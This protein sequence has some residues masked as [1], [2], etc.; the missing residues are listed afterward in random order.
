MQHKII[1]MLDPQSHHN[2]KA[3]RS[4]SSLKIGR[5]LNSVKMHYCSKF[6][7][8]N[9]SRWWVLACTCSKWGKSW[10]WS[11]IWPWR[12]QSIIPQ[13]NG[14]LNQGL[15]HLWSKFGDPS[16]NDWWVIVQ[17]RD[18]QTHT[19]AGNDNS[20]RPKLASGK[21]ILVGV[22]QS[23]KDIKFSSIMFQ[24]CISILC[25]FDLLPG[26][27]HQEAH[28]LTINSDNH[29]QSAACFENLSEQPNMKC[30]QKR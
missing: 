11:L 6:G 12:S 28:M 25:F 26:E 18:W 21:N 14:A 24:F 19:H 5:D 29:L 17:T 4:S 23:K 9:F 20:R 2:P 7:N 8:C 22:T 27:S 1:N 16:L 30:I 15:L 13:N 3:K 10:L